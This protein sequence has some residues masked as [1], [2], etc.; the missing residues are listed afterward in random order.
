MI[1]FSF[2][3][4]DKLGMMNTKMMAYFDA[5]HPLNGVGRPEGNQNRGW[6]DPDKNDGNL[7]AA[8]QAIHAPTIF[9][10]L[11]F[12]VFPDPDQTDQF[13]E[14]QYAEA[15]YPDYLE[16]ANPDNAIIN[17]GQPKTPPYLPAAVGSK[18]NGQG[19][20]QINAEKAGQ[21]AYGNYATEDKGSHSVR[22]GGLPEING[23]EAEYGFATKELVHSG[24]SPPNKP[25]RIGYS[26]KF[27]GMDA[28]ARTLR[29]RLN[30]AGTL[31]PI[32][33]PPTG[34][35]NIQNVYH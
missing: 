34:D 13:L 25:N 24:W 8:L 7:K 28:L 33:N 20:I 11:L 16:A 26:V 14:P 2:R 12:T 22:V 17:G 23:K 32:E 31:G 1:N 30:D 15:L 19:W 29:V 18:N 27:I 21:G 9:D 5:L 3:P 10:A 4:N 35:D 6:P